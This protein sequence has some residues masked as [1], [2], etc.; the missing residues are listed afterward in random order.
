MDHNVYI[1]EL[2]EI[3]QQAG[4]IVMSY[5]KTPLDIVTKSDNSPVTRAD[6][7]A[8]NFIVEALTK[9]TPSIPV[10]AEENNENNLEVSSDM[11]W[12]VD[13]LDGT[14][15]FIDQ[16]DEFTVNIGLIKNS[17]PSLGVIHVPTTN[18]TYYNIYDQAYKQLND[19]EPN[20]IF[21]NENTS[22]LTL[23]ASLSKTGMHTQNFIEKVKPTKLISMTSS[24][25]FCIIAEGK[26]DIYPRFGR[27]MEWDTAA[28]HAILS[29]AGG[30]VDDFDGNELKYGKA[31]FEN[32]NFIAYGKR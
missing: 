20:L 6:I 11:F 1:K 18:E 7:D 29:A 17:Y 21:I 9:L 32:G 16:N 12:L 10:I 28:G 13:P 15:G 27:T 8:N 26:A 31:N 2:K 3:A 5:Y 22:E 24:I 14:V 30:S 25:K 4:K 19:S 23:I